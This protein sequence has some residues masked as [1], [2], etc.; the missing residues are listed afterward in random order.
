MLYLE[1]IRRHWRRWLPVLVAVAATFGLTIVVVDDDGDGPPDRVIIERPVAPP[2][3]AVDGPDADT[4][5]DDALPL[6]ADAQDVALEVTEAPDEFDFADDLRGRDPTAAGVVDGP[7]ASQ[8][9]PGCRTSF[10][11]AF[12]GRVTGIRAIALHYTAGPNRAG[13]ADLDGLTAFSNNIGNQVSWHFGIDR[14]GHCSYNVPTTQ[15]AWT[16]SGLNSQTVNIE[17]VG[18]GRDPDYVGAGFA[19]LRAVVR[20]IGRIHRIPIRLGATD[21]RCNVTRTGV[22]THWMGGPCSGG[23]I[24]IRPYDVNAV[25]RRIALGAFTARDRRQ[26]RNVHAYR[27]RRRAG[28]PPTRSGKANQAR[29]L[30]Q[31]GNRGLRCRAGKPIRR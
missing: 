12:S 5:R 26:C 16:I 28:R 14:E 27:Q 3:T 11:R 1:A 7:L 23:H 29:R 13:W 22:V 21:G 31:L 19:K 10:V 30:E 24:D 25:I 9:W 6:N 17:V 2:A 8:Q 20:R 15:K 18:T 4:K